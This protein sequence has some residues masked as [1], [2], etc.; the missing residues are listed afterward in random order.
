[1][2]ET[3]KK[4]NIVVGA[5]REW[6][7]E[8][9]LPALLTYASFPHNNVGNITHVNSIE[10]LEKLVKD[11]KPGEYDFVML[12]GWSWQVSEELLAKIPVF[13][14]HPATDDRYSLGTPLQGQIEDGLK[15]TRHR[16]V[17]I[18]YPE[19]SERKYVQ[20]CDVPMNLW[21]SMDDILDQMAV[22][23]VEIYL[24]F[25][26][27]Y[28]N[29]TWVEWEK[30]DQMKKPRV[31]EDSR[32]TWGELGSMTTEQLY[33]KIRMLCYPYPMAFLEDERGR[34]YFTG[35]IF[36]PSGKK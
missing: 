24:K 1:M 15:K 36:V 28:P 22:T 8:K 9:V 13:S 32:I 11:A 14:E 35:A 29:F 31:P 17:K 10:G 26:S 23:S 3:K 18:S 25:L 5:Y 2:S 4:L 21:G 16:V 20:E 12:V 27:I 34:V 30:C 7:V 6:A 33:N 19:L